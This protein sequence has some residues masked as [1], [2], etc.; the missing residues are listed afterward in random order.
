M[1]NLDLGVTFKN[2]DLLT[3]A[4]THRSY[5]NE[6]PKVH[7]S[8]ERLEF[9]G[10]SVLQVLSSERLY[11][12]HPDFPEGKLT[13]LRA[14][15]VRAKTLAL[16]AARMNLGA[17]L[18]MSHGE[19]K[20]GGRDNPTLLANAFE[21]VVGALYL[22]Q[23]LESVKIFLE[24]YLFNQT[25]ETDTYDFKSQLQEKVQEKE[26]VSPTYKVLSETG[27]DHSKIFTVGVYI[28]KASLAKG[29]GKSKQEA[30][31]LAAKIA[32]KKLG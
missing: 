23:G 9:L 7:E 29:T 25:L 32:L 17:H 18:L 28:E 14:S 26:R 13:N 8:N 6:N 31:E 1:T 4:F 22:D 15:L 16:V 3:T 24:K 11:L 30:E 19:E 10:D 2:P 5:L 21:A 27:P 12:S 20:S